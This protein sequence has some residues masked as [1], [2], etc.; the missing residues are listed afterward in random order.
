MKNSIYISGIIS[1]IGL[2]VGALFKIQHWP[3]SGILLTIFII[4]FTLIFLPAALWNNFKKEKKNV[5]LYICIFFTIVI[6]FGAALFKILHWP[7][8]GIMVLV[9]LLAPFIIFLPA[10]IFY[11]N[12]TTNKDITNFIAILFLL[13][14]VALMD[15]FLAIGISKNIIDYTVQ[16]NQTTNQINTVLEG[17]NEMMYKNLPSSQPGLLDTRQIVNLKTRTKELCNLIDEMK[18]SLV[19]AAGKNNE[20]YISDSGD[21]NLWKIKGKDNQSLATGKFLY[22]DEARILKNQI[23]AYKEYVKSLNVKKIN[24]D[25]DEVLNVDD[26]NKN[27]QF[28]AWENALFEGSIMVWAIQKLDMI[29]MKVKMVE[30]EVLTTDFITGFTAE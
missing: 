29:K 20:F 18:F 11:Y 14:F 10:Y 16:I 24:F 15:A 4:F 6:C 1:A 2:T 25:L 8:A 9:A 28:K 22:T 13:V 7:G 26:I 12:K 19:I 3:A 30:S 23:E 21:I 17:K 5:F 27:D